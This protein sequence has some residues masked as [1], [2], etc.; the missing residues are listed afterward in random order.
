[1]NTR[2]RNGE[3]P[4]HTELQ[5][6]FDDSN[7]ADGAKFKQ[8]K[9]I[10]VAQLF[11]GPIHLNDPRQ[12]LHPNV[13]A[14]SVSWDDPDPRNGGHAVTVL[15]VAYDDI[16]RGQGHIIDTFLVPRVLHPDETQLVGALISTNA[17]PKPVGYSWS[18]I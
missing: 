15:Q 9:N 17:L 1:M 5:G 16:Y 11:V 7:P 18:A 3:P 2:W 12:T 10:D 4:N 6:L 13:A 8:A 14:F